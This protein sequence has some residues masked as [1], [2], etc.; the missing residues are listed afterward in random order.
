[1]C[2]QLFPEVIL[3]FIF[4]WPETFFLILLC[5]VMG[6]FEDEKMTSL[7]SVLKSTNT[8]SFCVWLAFSIANITKTCCETRVNSW[9]RNCVTSHWFKLTCIL[10]RLKFSESTSHNLPKLSV[11]SSKEQRIIK[12]KTRKGKT[13]LAAK[14]QGHIKNEQ[15]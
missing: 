5:F 6:N 10:L 11:S 7:V 4:N 13:K 3:M 14:L 9:E 2:L 8:D 12:D 15:P 1:M